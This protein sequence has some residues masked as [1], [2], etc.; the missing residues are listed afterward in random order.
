[1]SFPPIQ[2][3]YPLSHDT[4]AYKK[5]VNSVWWQ[6]VNKEIKKVLRKVETKQITLKS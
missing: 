6:T 1:M 3:F 2:R 4:A 5:V